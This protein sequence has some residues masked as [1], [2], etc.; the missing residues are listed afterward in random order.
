MSRRVAVSTVGLSTPRTTGVERYAVEVLR[1]LLSLEAEGTLPFRVVPVVHEWMARTLDVDCIV[2]P[3]RLNRA[4]AV[5]VWQPAALRRL[6]V[7]A[8]YGLGLAIPTRL[9][10]PWVQLVHDTVVWDQTGTASLGARIYFGPSLRRG[11]R[12]GLV[13]GVTVTT[14]ATA[15]GLRRRVPDD[16]PIDVVGAGVSDMWTYAPPPVAGP[17][18]VLLSVGTIE[19]RKDLGTLDDAAAAL[20]SSGLEFEWRHVG[21]DGWGGRLMLRHATM[22]GSVDDSE[23]LRQYRSAHVLC[24]TSSDEGFNLPVMEALACGL[25]CVISDIETHRELYGDVATLVPVRSPEAV[26]E[27]I[28]ENLAGHPDRPHHVVPRWRDVSRRTGDAL[29]RAIS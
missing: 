10:A 18:W 12:R 14:H 20:R 21:R 15:H 26:A 2:V 5:E 25:P 28:L 1:G 13:C 24:S 7:A 22:L 23:L 6:S 17:P 11:L 16:V 27:G 8:V 3:R 4:L 19:P 29:T 9:V